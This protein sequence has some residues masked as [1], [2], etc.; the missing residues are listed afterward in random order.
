[1][2]AGIENNTSTNRRLTLSQ[3]HWYAL[4]AHDVLKKFGV[5]SQQGLSPKEAKDR[6][7][8]YGENVLQK[9]A[10]YN[11]LGILLAQFKNGLILILIG[12]AILAGSIGDTKDAIVILVAIIFNTVLGFLQEYRAE[13]SMQ[14]LK[15]MLAQEA[16]VYRDGC[17]KLINATDLVPGDIVLLEA[18]DKIPADGRL[19]TAY[20]LEADESTLTGESIPVGKIIDKLNNQPIPVAERSNML[21]MNNVITRG[22]GEMVV[23][24]TGFATETG[25]LAQMLI[26]VEKQPTPL[27]RQLNTL[28]KK[29]A[30]MAII[31]IAII[32]LM[33]I[34]R[35]IPLV[36]MILI[37]IALAVAAIPE[38]LPTVVTITLAL[39]MQ[40][41][42]R[43][44]AII[45]KLSAVETLGCTT[46]ICTDKTGT[47]TLNQM[48]VR[49]LFFSGNSFD[50]SGKGYSSDGEITVG[51]ECRLVLPSL[52]SAAALCN[53]SQ[54]K[55]N[56]FIGDPTEVALLVLAKKGNLD[57]QGT[58]NKYPRVAEIPFDA[59]HKFMATFHK[60][61]T[62][63]RVFVKGAPEIL[64]EK[65]STLLSSEDI[66]TITASSRKNV[67]SANEKFAEQGLR[68]LALASVDLSL[69]VFKSEKDLF[70][71]IANLTFVGL[72]AM[73]DPLRSE[74]REAIQ[75]CYKAG[76]HVMMI[77]G[78]HK[79]TACAIAC[80]LG[81][82]GD[83]VTGMELSNMSDQVLDQRIKDISVFARV[84]PEDKVRIVQA[85]KRTKNVVA[86][87]GDGVNDA[88]ALKNAD[89]GIAM[90]TTG[91]D[92]AKEVA[93]MVLTD[94]NFS[95]II[96]AIEEGRTIYSNIVKFVRFQLSTN[97]GAIL[98]MFLA[99]IIGLPAPFNAIQILLVNVIMDGPPALSLG[100]DK[101]RSIIMLDP[102]R[103]LKSNIINWPRITR[104]IFYGIIMA[105]GTLG[106]LYYGL[107]TMNSQKA[108]TL[109][110]TTFV[111]FQLFNVFNVRHEKET[112]FTRDFFANSKLWLS[113][114]CVLIFQ[115]FIVYWPFMQPVFR[116]SSLSLNNWLLV[117]IVSSTIIWF[118][119]IYKFIC[120][121]KNTEVAK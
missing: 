53:D 117:V 32:F 74:A 71:H 45:R 102:P 101:S 42:A 108:H 92:I 66:N 87:T 31:V 49:K 83:A 36:E 52:L 84:A 116:T 3:H 94:D 78:D 37:A 15:G 86:M 43:R 11:A 47:L 34:L 39:G 55:A 54:I 23:T 24:A 60:D 5:E 61:G 111:L 112:M 14:A 64:L 26:S 38:G 35:N 10:S 69:E 2:S 91:T 93:S 72:V 88:P 27:Q 9:A 114:L 106:I 16:K 57:L 7:S 104:V 95:T 22:R 105:A 79:T 65:C 12:A 33:G 28:G 121:M 90:G 68:V 98:T 97:F 30:I 46:T 4:S 85:L 40:R 41:M 17:Q 59:R 21:Y 50:V 76:I 100:L 77:T 81:L 115:M 107:Q 48:T 18:G 89:I 13:R 110:F 73:E 62:K 19:I 1:M 103:G 63:I 29:L 99:P 56:Q 70:K 82:T 119:E 8:V 75:L 67:L 109:A 51:K 20:T 96:K 120:R 118:D 25:R 80:Q 44:H 113:I 6:L 58:K